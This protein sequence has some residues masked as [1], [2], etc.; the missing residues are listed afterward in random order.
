GGGGTTTG[1]GGSGAGGTCAANGRDPSTLGPPCC[2]KNGGVAHCLPA[3]AVPPAL[4]SG[5]ATC[6]TMTSEPGACVPDEIIMA[7]DAFV[8]APCQSIGGSEG[9][10]LG[11]C[12]DKIGSD[13]QAGLLPQ[14][15]CAAGDVCVPCINPI[16][17]ESTGACDIKGPC[18]AGDGGTDDGGG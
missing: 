9:V 2:T 13:P 14:A 15:T 11:L 18:E 17:M 7:G 16:T 1:G 8:P 3:A 6:T 10:C 12:I 4:L 5:F